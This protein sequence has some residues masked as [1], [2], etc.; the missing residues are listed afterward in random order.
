MPAGA[1]VTFVNLGAADTDVLNVHVPD[2]RC[3]NLGQIA[4][5]RRERAVEIYYLFLF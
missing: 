4:S 1:A 2:G 3:F 5:A